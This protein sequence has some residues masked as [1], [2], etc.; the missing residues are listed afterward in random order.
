MAPVLVAAYLACGP[1]TKSRGIMDVTQYQRAN[2]LHQ[3]TP[4]YVAPL[5]LKCWVSTRNAANR[6]T[7]KKTT[8]YVW[9]F[10]YVKLLPFDREQTEVDLPDNA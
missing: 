1:P 2:N 10:G 3:I 5:V 6:T 8:Y 9:F 4:N 7:T